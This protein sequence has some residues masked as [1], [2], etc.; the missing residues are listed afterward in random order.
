MRLNETSYTYIYTRVRAREG[1][2]LVRPLVEHFEF[3][4][5]VT[6]LLGS[7]RKDDSAKMNED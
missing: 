1:Y 7:E 3:G 6:E 2:W 4:F 5:E